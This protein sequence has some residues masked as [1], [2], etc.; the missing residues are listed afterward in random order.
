MGVA[1]SI[2]ATPVRNQ[3]NGGSTMN[4][5]I[6][7][8]LMSY[9]KLERWNKSKNL[10]KTPPFDKWTYDVVME[11]VWALS[12]LGIIE[13]RK[14]TATTNALYRIDETN[15]RWWIDTLKQALDR[16]PKPQ[17]DFRTMAILYVIGDFSL[18]HH[19]PPRQIEL[20]YSDQP[21]H[22]G[23]LINEWLET[24]GAIA[25]DPGISGPPHIR[26]ATQRLADLG[27]MVERG[28]KANKKPF[29]LTDKGLEIVEYLQTLHWRDWPVIRE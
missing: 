17:M 27:Y 9:F 8:A 2:I 15:A 22:H 21:G 5:E 28:A 24:S 29:I 14:N 20:Y 3:T 13:K 23:G 16:I 11:H 4:V 26:T 19:R 25:E 7:Q 1:K 12:R 18:K 6:I 10:S